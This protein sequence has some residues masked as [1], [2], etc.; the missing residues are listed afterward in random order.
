[1]VCP[2]IHRAFGYRGHCESGSGFRL[3]LRAVPIMTSKL[4][5]PPSHMLI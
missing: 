5:D 3:K 1:M 2:S 4:Y